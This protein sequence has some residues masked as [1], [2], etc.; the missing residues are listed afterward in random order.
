MYTNQTAFAFDPS[1]TAI[2]VPT[3][4]S[5]WHGFT[6]K[7]RLAFVLLCF[8]LTACGIG[9]AQEAT[10]TILGTVTDST[11][12]IVP[13][14]SITIK[15]VGTNQTRTATAGVTG[16]FTFPS[17]SP[18]VYE[19]D[20]T[21]PGFKSVAI[22]D[23]RL[24][25]GDHTRENARLEI[26]AVSE[27]VTVSATTSSLQTDAS[28][29]NTTLTERAVQD[30]PLNGRNFI[31]LVLLTPGASDA[32]PDGSAT[33]FLPVDRR[34]TSAV[35]FNG[36]AAGTN[37][38][39][40]DGLDNIERLVGTIGI[41]P[42]ID[43]INEVQVQSN[44]YTAEG[45]RTAGGVIN[46]VTKSGTN[47][48]HGSLYEFFRND[49]LNTYPYA[50]GAK[51]PKTELRQNQ[52]GGSLG[53]P[54]IK[55]KL[56]FFTD[57]EELRQ[58]AGTA[59][60][61]FTV[62][63]L[64]EEQHPGDF[65]DTG[66]IVIPTAQIDPAGLDYFSLLPA[67][68]TG[69]NA[70]TGTG[71]G[72]LFVRTSDGR[73][74]YTLSPKS[75][76]FARFSYNN[77]ASLTPAIFP[78][79]VVAGLTI[80]P[81]GFGQGP[82]N[83][84]ARNAALGY[85]RI[86][87]SSLLFD[88]KASY[89]YINNNSG[90]YNQGLNPNA[91]F[92]QPGINLDSFTSGLATVFIATAGTPLGSSGLGIPI[93]EKDNTYQ[94]LA[95]VTYTHGPHTSKAGI[96]AIRRDV[97][98]AG[99]SRGEGQFTF[100][101]FSNLLQGKPTSVQ[102][103]FNFFGSNY[104]TYED[105]AFFQDD[106]RVTTK[107]TLN[108]GGRYDIFTPFTEK[109]SRLANFNPVNATIIQANQAGINQYAGLHNSYADVAP[110]IGFA[111]NPITGTSVHGGFGLTYYPGSLSL[112]GVLRAPPLNYVLG[113]C[114][115]A[116]GTCAAGFNQFS[117]GLPLPV[118]VNSSVPS[119]GIGSSIDPNFTNTRVAQYNL[120][121]QQQFGANVVS[122]GYVGMSGRHVAIVLPDINA[123]LPN[124]CGLLTGAASATCYANLRP[125]NALAPNL[126]TVVQ[127]QSTGNSN[128]NSMQTSFDRRA[129]KGLTLGATYTWAHDIDE[130]GTV[131]NAPGSL[132][133]F[134]N[135]PSNNR[136]FERGNSYYDARNRI[137]TRINYLLPFGSS[138]HGLRAIAGKGWQGNI[139]Y[140]WQTGLPF[141]VT[142][143]S[144]ISNAVTGVNDRPNQISNNLTTSNPSFAKFFN[145]AAFVAQT[146]GNFGSER[147]NQLYGPHYRHL[148]VS[149]FKT[150]DVSEHAKLEFRAEVFNLTNTTN[151]FTPNY[152]LQ[153]ALFGQLTSTSPS[154]NPRL[155]QLAAKVNF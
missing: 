152:T 155:I 10:G 47:A 16:E 149:L 133:A 150:F 153:S 141:S 109:Q 83:D 89:L 81:E 36:Q 80:T 37:H 76:I 113:T 130:G 33:G 24:T 110:R 117:A 82:A 93:Q 105:Y 135:D 23:I 12:S 88:V 118:A 116:A 154:Y 129:T 73:V 75:T 115:E 106:W 87:N 108:L 84:G 14:A 119:G 92:G 41:R 54:A 86:V 121:V 91:A 79:K 102:R 40:I 46:V 95:S 112:S 34:Q 127:L 126:T 137:T 136:A 1:A 5:G 13:G 27:V 77:V 49:K 103:N 64:Y 134:G 57:Y 38:Q 32:T 60:A 28:S 25:A 45:G 7:L 122:I 131:G 104:R 148:D 51:L 70:Y 147:R 44:T 90:A 100:P 107:L 11:G 143:S 132:L 111:Y 151:F 72:N 65:S 55:D 85:Q 58:I 18:G 124:T 66:G 123:P 20:V 2:I 63:S 56:F 98:Q 96:S 128:Y 48:F 30:L 29:V 140:S 3:Q 146:V 142:N 68:N 114:S 8:V 78:S 61:K 22:S 138:L 50:F 17:L 67:P 31:G 120:F 4:T 52:F 97:F 19:V 139:L 43:A 99:D 15:N 94:L 74:D 62:P 144:N 69:T 145:T 42:S 53:G 35:S 101:G 59:P 6:S 71:K 21:A 125:F 26:G 39:L 9:T